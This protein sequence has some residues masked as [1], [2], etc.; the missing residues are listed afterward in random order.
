MADQDKNIADLTPDE[1]AQ[2][3]AQVKQ[4]LNLPEDADDFQVVATLVVLCAQ[5]QQTQTA[6]Q[7]ERDAAVT[8]AA[9]ARGEMANRD[10]EAFKD[11]IGSKE[12]ADFWHKQLL[13]NREPTLALLGSLRKR[14]ESAKAPAKPSMASR[15]TPVLPNRQVI[16]APATSPETAK[17]QKQAQAI[18]NRA[19]ELVR[20]EGRQYWDAFDQAVREITLK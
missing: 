3:M 8:E 18:A 20:T 2:Y 5:L 11:V 14:V 9:A 4:K 12:E 6:T 1:K 17:Q 16:T 10:L 7:N 15:T 13:A 19:N